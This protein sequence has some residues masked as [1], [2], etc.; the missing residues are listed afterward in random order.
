MQSCRRPKGKEIH[1]K[2]SLVA[3]VRVRQNIIIHE[4]SYK[5]ANNTFGPHQ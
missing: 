1:N 2:C 5:L 3:I 4:F